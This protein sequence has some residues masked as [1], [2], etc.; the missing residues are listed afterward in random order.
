MI[1][2]SPVRDLKPSS[3]IIEFATKTNGETYDLQRAVDHEVEVLE[4]YVT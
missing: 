2:S 4:A 3:D 1:E